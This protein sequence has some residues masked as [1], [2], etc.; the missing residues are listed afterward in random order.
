VQ[1]A[2]DPGISTWPEEHPVLIGSG[3]GAC[4]ATVFPCQ[5]HCPKCSKADT[6]DVLLPR[7]DTVIGGPMP[8]N[9]DGGLIGNGEPIGAS[10]LRQVHELVRQLRGEAGERQVPGEPR[11]GVRTALRRTRHRGRDHRDARTWSPLSR[12]L[13]NV[14]V[15]RGR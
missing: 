6:S 3:C 5:S 7:R 14:R 11:G 15:A 12:S 10:G 13:A 9:T 1:K 4:G 8:I 2:I